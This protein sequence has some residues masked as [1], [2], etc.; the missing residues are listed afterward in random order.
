MYPHKY[1]PIITK[2]LFDQVQKIK[3]GF[4]K[5]RYKF[6]GLSYMYRGLLRCGHCGL[7]VTPEKHKGITYYHC[8]QYNGKHGAEWLR[9]D[10]ITEQVGNIFKRLQLPNWVLEQIVENLNAVHQDKMDF[11]NKQYDKLTKEHTTITKMSDNLYL[12]KLKGRITDDEYDK[13]Y[14]SFREQIADIDTRLAMLQEA[15][16]NYYITAKCLLDLSN[17]AYELFKSS[18]V[19]ER[20]QLIKLV[21]SNLRVEGKLVRYDGLKPFDTILNYADNQLWLRE[22]CTNITLDFEAIIQAFQDIR[23]IG[24][25]RQRWNEIKKLQIGIPLST[26]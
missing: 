9:E 5:N 4:N 3:A 19:E 1:P 7:S 16:D 26:I 22:S 18:E 23:Y 25:L 13:F 11:H 2:A 15:E 20:R 8:T 21:L 24:E 12:D 17:R 10:T 6:A 14:Q